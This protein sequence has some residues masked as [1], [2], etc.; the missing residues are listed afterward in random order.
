MEGGPLCGKACRRPLELVK[1]LSDGYVAFYSALYVYRLVDAPPMDITIA[2]YMKS[3]RIVM[4]HLTYRLIAYGKGLKAT[5]KT[6]TGFPLDLRLYMTIY[7]G[8]T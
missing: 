3:K 6:S 7:I 1:H 8:R 5:R 4:D 2:T